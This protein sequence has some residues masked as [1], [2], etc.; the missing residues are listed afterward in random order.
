M[1]VKMNRNATAAMLGIS[2]QTLDTWV[3]LGKIKHQPR[4]LGD[5]QQ[6]PLE[7]DWAEVT[8][9]LAAWE[10][11]EGERKATS[12]EAIMER[13]RED[14]RQG[15]KSGYEQEAQLYG[16]GKD[17]YQAN[18]QAIAQNPHLKPKTPK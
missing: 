4:K 12:W 9:D 6:S 13:V 11:A 3:K 10:R 17:A 7:F 2:P 15:K 1:S 5:H 14:K 18:Q 16:G 8:A